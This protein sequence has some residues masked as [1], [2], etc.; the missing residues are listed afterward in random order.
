MNLKVKFK[1][2]LAL[3]KHTSHIQAQSLI[4][5]IE[6]ANNIKVLE[7]QKDLLKEGF[8]VELVRQPT[9]KQAIIRIIAKL[10]LQKTT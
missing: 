10:I 3:F 1:R 6:I 4:V 9:V 8:M 5:P 7:I 2:I